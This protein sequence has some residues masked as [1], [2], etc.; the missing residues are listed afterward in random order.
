[1]TKSI[2]VGIIGLSAER[3][4]AATAHVPAIRAVPGLELAGLCAST[5]ESGARAA[6]ALWTTPE[7]TVKLC[8]RQGERHVDPPPEVL[9]YVPAEQIADD[10]SIGTNTLSS[11]LSAASGRFS[12]PT[13]MLHE[14]FRGRILNP[15]RTAWPPLP[16][17]EDDVANTP[18]HGTPC[19][20]D[21]DSVQPG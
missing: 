9:D 10:G 14:T 3:G 2:R 12:Q 5:P 4:W 20:L 17:F 8:D 19:Q 11:A 6:K 1:M 7:D 21:G 15:E 18:V 16:T 13:R